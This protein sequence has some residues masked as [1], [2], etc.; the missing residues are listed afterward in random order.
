MNAA[1]LSA[2]REGCLRE[3]WGKVRH[4]KKRGINLLDEFAIGFRLVT[5]ALPFGVVLEGFP[6]G[7][8]GFAAGM[9]QDVNEGLALERFVGGRPVCHVLDTVLFEE[10]YGVLAKAAEQVIELALES[11]IDA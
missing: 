5:D 6:V 7:C 2:D 9:R 4:H 8:G 10:F 11:V 3:L 1:L